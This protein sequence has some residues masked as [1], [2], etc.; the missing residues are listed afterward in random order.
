[1]PQA[2]QVAAR[3]RPWADLGQAVEKTV[4]AITPTR[5]NRLLN[6]STRP[7]SRRWSRR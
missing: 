6:L 3:Y 5:P 1:M 2:D 4:N 7:T